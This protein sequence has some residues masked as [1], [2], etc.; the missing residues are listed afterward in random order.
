MHTFNFLKFLQYMW[1]KSI[2]DHANA[3]MLQFLLSLNDVL[4]ILHT[5]IVLFMYT[6]NTIH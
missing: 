4:I 5:L 1:G 3:E 6:F 2:I